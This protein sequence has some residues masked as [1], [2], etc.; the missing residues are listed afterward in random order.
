MPETT[1]IEIR[2][3]NITWMKKSVGKVDSN[4]N[5]MKMKCNENQDH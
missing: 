4:L 3:E 1:R 5:Y 2:K